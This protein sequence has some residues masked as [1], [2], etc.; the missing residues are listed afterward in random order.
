MNEAMTK[1]G[2]HIIITILSLLIAGGI[3]LSYTLYLDISETKSQLDELKVRQARI[4]DKLIDTT[5]DV[6]RL[7]TNSEAISTNISDL[8]S[9]MKDLNADIKA[10]NNKIDK[11][12]VL[13]TGN[14]K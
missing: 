14:K 12:I 13:N 5:I 2:N 11:L 10:L 8:K 9:N 1:F 3:P 4:N 6:E 7:K